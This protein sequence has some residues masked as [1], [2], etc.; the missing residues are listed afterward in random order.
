MF[1]TR[2]LEVA[3]GIVFIFLVVSIICSAIREVIES[4]RKPRAAYLEHGIRELLHD[5]GGVGLARALYEHPLSDP[6]TKALVKE[7]QRKLNADQLGIFG[8]KTEA[9]VRELQRS[10]GMVP[11][12]I[13]GHR[14]WKAIDALP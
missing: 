5:P 9:A 6:S 3:M 1:G 14:T 10:L 7:M 13:V 4:W 11:D 12:G 8:P 2:I